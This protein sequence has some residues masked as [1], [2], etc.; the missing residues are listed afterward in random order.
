[1]LMLET[2]VSVDGLG[3]SGLNRELVKLQNTE[4]QEKTEPLPMQIMS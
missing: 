3:Y 4:S 1:M 2:E